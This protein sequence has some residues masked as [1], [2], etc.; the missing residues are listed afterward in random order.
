MKKNIFSVILYLGL[1]LLCTSCFIP[2]EEKKSS[3]EASSATV[4][5]DPESIGPKNFKLEDWTDIEV[6]DL[7][8]KVDEVFSQLEVGDSVIG[9]SVAAPGSEIFCSESDFTGSRVKID[10]SV[11]SIKFLA[12]LSSCAKKSLQN[13]LASLGQYQKVLMKVGFLI[14]T[15]CEGGI[16]QGDGGANLVKNFFLGQIAFNDLVAGC[17][18][19]PLT[20]NRSRTRNS[21]VL[22]ASGIYKDGRIFEG[23]TI[24]MSATMA[25]SGGPCEEEYDPSS[26]K[27]T[28]SSC[29]VYENNRTWMIIA[30]KK[31][32]S[33]TNLLQITT[34][35][36][37][38][39]HNTDMYYRDGSVSVFINGWKGEAV[40]DKE[41][42]AP[43]LSLTKGGS[44]E[45]F[46]APSVKRTLE[47][48]LIAV[49][50]DFE[51][52]QQVILGSEII[53]N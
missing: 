25:A 23:H 13:Q 41:G 48:G 46:R 8:E 2:K 51:I 24:N 7:Q 45:D 42:G 3:S 12:D 5:I 9:D 52:S 37:S 30:G 47:F 11:V 43:S 18:Q 49:P 26:Q 22:D 28:Y 19:F 16:I 6:K 44:T 29:N 31:E 20:L 14:E 27:G 21:M 33:K 38:G 35:G 34:K 39:Q 36:L 4:S 15:S 32:S 53:K 40:L 50:V 17:S 10:Q 1:L